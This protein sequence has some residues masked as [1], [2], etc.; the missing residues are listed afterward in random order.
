MRM[1]VA[2]VMAPK[3]ARLDMLVPELSRRGEF[4]ALS[5][6]KEKSTFTFSRMGNAL[7]SCRLANNSVG[8]CRSSSAGGSG[9]T[10]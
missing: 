7:N 10:V 5:A 1:F 3:A 4:S 6:W 9:V 8:P 2:L